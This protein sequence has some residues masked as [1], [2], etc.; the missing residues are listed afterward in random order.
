MII[1]G[2]MPQPTLR[3]SDQLFAPLAEAQVSDFEQGLAHLK[4]SGA[5]GDAM[6]LGVHW[7]YTSLCLSYPL[8]PT[9]DSP[10]WAA[11]ASGLRLE[12]QR[13]RSTALERFS[14][15]PIAQLKARKLDATQWATWPKTKGDT[16]GWPDELPAWLDLKSKCPQALSLSA[17]QLKRALWPLSLLAVKGKIGPISMERWYQYLLADQALRSLSTWAKEREVDPPLLIQEWRWWL[18]RE[19][20]LQLA[21][22]SGVRLGW[23]PINRSMTWTSSQLYTESCS[24]WLRLHR[25]SLGLVVNTTPQ[26]REG[27]IKA[28]A[29]V[30]LLA[31]LCH[32]SV[33][34]DQAALEA[35]ELAI[36]S[37]QDDRAPTTLDLTRY[38]QLRVFI[39]L[40]RYQEA[41]ALRTVIPKSSSPL[42]TPFA[43]ALGEAMMYAGQEEALMGFSTEIFRDRSWRRDPFLRALFY[44]F[45][46]SLTLYH[47]EGRVLEL[48]ED[49]GPRSELYERVFL[50]AHVALDQGQAE[51][52]QSA[53][54]WLLGHHDSAIWRPRYHALEARAALLRLDREG[55][56]RALRTISP[57]TGSIVDAIHKGRRSSFFERQDQALADLLRIEIPRIA[58]WPSIPRS[59]EKQRVAWLDLIAKEMQR[60]LR[61]RPNT[62]ARKELISLY[63]ALKQNLPT[64]KLRA[65]SE[66]IGRDHSPSILIGYVKVSGVDLTH[67]EPR[68]LTIKP[69]EAPSLTLLPQATL[70][71]LSWRLMWPVYPSTLGNLSP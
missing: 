70:N 28:S 24:I 71:P 47:F 68:D 1:N 20:A 32:S 17:P 41:S 33:K 59:A 31:G 35:W 14:M 3:A 30:A 22:L 5:T 27:L 66:R 50:F 63:R 8:S 40:G 61:L 49:L 46:R 44:L 7:L 64:D 48:L 29:Q 69:R 42:F 57:S 16:E 4:S 45:I 18:E 6:Q 12:S 58:G 51:S 37:A 9:Y 34:E 25:E 36:L 26:R 60:F 62:K 52:G 2:C 13:A 53:T 39:D 67:L 11:L 56:M 55:F 10:L 19:Q 23:P 15:L 21:Q 43:F 65:Y 38:H 54:T